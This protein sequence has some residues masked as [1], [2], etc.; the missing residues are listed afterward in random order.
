MISGMT[1]YGS[2][3]VAAGK[4]KGVVEVKSLN[5]RYFDLA[6][7]LLIGFAALENKVRD[8]VGKHIRRGR[9]TV[10]LKILEKPVQEVAINKDV[11]REYLK[12]A[13]QLHKEFDL[14]TNLSLADVIRLPGVVEAREYLLD[15]ESLW[16]AVE[17]S[18]DR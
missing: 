10:S 16:P 14:D 5:H 4:V 11:V 12:S 15:P 7:Y 17:K 1:G 13:K 8:S 18:L 6:F 3:T 9:V 2:A